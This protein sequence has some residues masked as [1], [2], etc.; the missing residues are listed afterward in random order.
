MVDLR[1][2]LAKKKLQKATNPID[3]YNSLDRMASKGELRKAQKEILENWYKNK[4]DDKDL[5]IKLSTGRGKTLIGLLILQAKINNGEGPCLYLCPDNYLVEQTC[6]EAKNFGIDFCTG[7]GDLPLEFENGEKILITNVNKLFN[8][9]TKFRTKGNSIP[10]NTI[11]FDDSHACLDI[12]QSCFTIVIERKFNKDLFEKF[13]NLFEKDLEYQGQATLEAIKN[14]D[15]TSYLPIPYWSW[16]DHQSDVIKMLS[17]FSNEKFLTFTWDSVKDNLDNC[18][19]LISG[20]KIEITPYLLPLEK[21][22]SFYNAK[23][24][25]F[26][27]AT[28]NNDSFFIKHL[29]IG[30]ETI[31]NPLTVKNDVFTGEKMILAPSLIDTSLDTDYAMNK[32][33]KKQDDNKTPT[34]GICVLSPSFKMAEAWSHNGARIVD[35]G[36]IGKAIESLKK[37]NF[38]ETIVFANR[39]DGLD[40]PDNACRILIFDGLPYASNLLD[41][42]YEECLSDTEITNTKIIQKIEQGLG[43]NVR[44]ER[45]YGAILLFRNELIRYVMTNKYKKYFS[46]QTRKQIEI[47]KELTN[48][49]KDEVDEKGAGKA[50]CDLLKKIIKREDDW[51]EYYYD[52]M[53]DIPED[54]TPKILT[55]LVIQRQAEYENYKGKSNNTVEILRQYLNDNKENMSDNEKG[56]YLQ[57]IARYLYKSAKSQSIKT[58]I[59]AHEKNNLLLKPN[60]D[61]NIKLLKSEKINQA[62][63][64]KKYIEKYSTPSDLELDVNEILDFM[65]FGIDYKKFE[66]SIMKI[67]KFLGFASEQ[68][69][70]QYREGPDNLWAVAPS[71][72]FVIECKNQIFESRGFLSQDEIGQMNNT[73]GWFQKNYQK[74]NGTYIMFAPTNI[75]DNRVAFVKDVNIIR[76]TELKKF[77]KNILAFTKD[78]INSNFESI[79]SDDIYKLLTLHKLNYKDFNTYFTKPVDTLVQKEIKE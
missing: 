15:S 31:K 9:K 7:E 55:E 43:R 64:I 61:I 77:R 68:P 78:L 12:I 16:I 3:I 32:F 5:I 67:G 41:T 33:I 24:R 17:P 35:Y 49:A 51:K 73:I 23:N 50:L 6:I 63:Y 45:D 8:A 14:Y 22:G 13:I 40:L 59:A 60:A 27:S 37:E 52:E 65:D 74:H 70:Q 4:K 58:Q 62:L 1:E 72:Y 42:Y 48:M 56:W 30:E 25:I 28:V 29:N 11:V 79:S 2:R 36:D 53:K 66:N 46:L 69:D 76:K 47:G 39:Y 10:V 57:Q 19:C 20:N 21:F 38:D 34:Y 54:T 44:G 26:M 18:M 75:I 71:E